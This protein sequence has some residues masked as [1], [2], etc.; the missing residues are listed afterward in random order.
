MGHRIPPAEQKKA[1]ATVNQCHLELWHAREDARRV[2]E[3]M[4]RAIRDVED[5]EN[6]L[7]AAMRRLKRI[8]A[9]ITAVISDDP[10]SRLTLLR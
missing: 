5:A 2:D 4:R 10:S 3:M 7:D 6:A 8:D 1:V 9:P